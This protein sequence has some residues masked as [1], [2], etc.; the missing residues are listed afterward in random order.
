MTRWLIAR[1]V[2]RV[3]PLRFDPDQAIG[4]DSEIELR[5][6]IRGRMTVLT[7]AI[8][9]RACAVRPGPSPDAGAAATVGLANLIRMAI[10]DV[11]WPQLLSR[12]SFQLSGDPFLALRLP[13]LFRLPA[14]A[15]GAAIPVPVPV[16]SR[17]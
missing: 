14:A 15:R 7:I 5:I 12:G 2:A 4:I 6:G 9:D 17:S 11:G 3:I 13:T 16:G 8:A 10:G 1:I